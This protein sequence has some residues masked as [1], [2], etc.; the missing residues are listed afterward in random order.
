MK[1][2]KEF[3]VKSVEDLTTAVY[4]DKMEV[5]EACMANMIQIVHTMNFFSWKA[6]IVLAHKK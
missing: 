1:I 3:P 2:S 5:S 6:F 4:V